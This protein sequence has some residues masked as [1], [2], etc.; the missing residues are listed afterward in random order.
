MKKNK[1]K[2]LFISILIIIPLS[3]FIKN[4]YLHPKISAQE[5]MSILKTKNTTITRWMNVNLDV[6]NSEEAIWVS[7]NR[8]TFFAYRF[9]SV[10]DAKTKSF[11]F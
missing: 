11:S 6:K 2:I 3:I 10:S 5:L 9:S 8:G 4:T 1:I 7:T